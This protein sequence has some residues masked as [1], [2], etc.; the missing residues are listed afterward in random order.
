MDSKRPADKGGRRRVGLMKQREANIWED[1]DRSAS[2]QKPTRD[3]PSKESLPAGAPSL[4][5][6]AFN[7]NELTANEQKEQLLRQQKREASILN[8]V[9]STYAKDKSN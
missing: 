4:D 8:F 7:V 9:H 3:V 5:Q 1:I 2:S 6:S